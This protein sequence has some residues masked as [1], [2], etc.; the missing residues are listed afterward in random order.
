VSFLHRDWDSISPSICCCVIAANHTISC[1]ISSLTQSMQ[2][3]LDSVSQQ[4]RQRSCDISLLTLSEENKISLLTQPMQ[5]ALGC[6]SQ[7][8]QESWDTSFNSDNAVCPRMFVSMEEARCKSSGW[9]WWK[10]YPSAMACKL[11]VE[12]IR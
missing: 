6:V 2:V 4:R 10:R 5:F 3:T 12:P 8:R 11:K 7:R 9:F 1:H